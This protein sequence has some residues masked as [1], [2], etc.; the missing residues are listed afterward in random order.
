MYAMHSLIALPSLPLQMR[1]QSNCLTSA[2]LY[3]SPKTYEQIAR[4]T[5]MV[6]TGFL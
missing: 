1:F 4:M 6:I 2:I 5:V 3:V